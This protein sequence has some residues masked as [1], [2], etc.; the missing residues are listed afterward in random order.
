MRQDVQLLQYEMDKRDKARHVV[1]RHSSDMG[2]IIADE[3]NVLRCD[4]QL[5]RQY[6]VG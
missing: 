3:A 5:T 1:S 2:S 4:L 6:I